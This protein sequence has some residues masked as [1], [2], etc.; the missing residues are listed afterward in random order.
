MRLF[1]RSGPTNFDLSGWYK[2][3]TRLLNLIS[4]ISIISGREMVFKTLCI[5]QSIGCRRF[6]Y[7]FVFTYNRT[8]NPKVVGSN[9]AP[10]TKKY[11]GLRSNSESLNFWVKFESPP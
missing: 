4:S 11:Q 1:E 5:G 8:H 2:I 3:G 6:T 7:L 9:P 10:A